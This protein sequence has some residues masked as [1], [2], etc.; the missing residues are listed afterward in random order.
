MK[1]RRNKLI[2]FSL[3]CVIIFIIATLSNNRRRSK[4]I[5]KE[6]SKIQI[7]MPIEEVIRIY[8]EPTLISNSKDFCYIPENVEK[9]YYNREVDVYPLVQNELIVPVIISINK[10]SNEVFEIVLGSY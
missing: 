8:G 7:G 2:I 9:Y 4:L 6:I 3:V 5:D 1:K 10:D